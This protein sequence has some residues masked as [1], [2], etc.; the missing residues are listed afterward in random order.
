MVDF[1]NRNIV[2]LLVVV[3]LFIIGFLVNDPFLLF[4][5]SYGRSPLLLKDVAEE[6]VRRIVVI[7]K[8]ERRVFTRTSSGWLLEYGGNNYN[9]DSKKIAENLKKLLDIRRYQKVSSSKDKFQ[10]LE[11]ADDNFHIILEG[12]N[13]KVLARLQLGKAASNYTSTLVRRFGE[14][15]VYSAKGS[16]RSDWNQEVDAYREKTLLLVARPNIKEVVISGKSSFKLAQLGET[17]WQLSYGKKDVP[18]DK[19]RVESFLN[20]LSELKGYRFYKEKSPPLAYKVV[21]Q[22]QGNLTKEL[23]IYGPLKEGEYVA[24]STDN[25]FLLTIS[26]YQVENYLTKPEEFEQKNPGSP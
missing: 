24:S 14:D 4:E 26:K 15:D 16:L 1:R 17:G 2:L 21:L 23:S 11:V 20:Q 3:V 22:L 7:N 18:A 19:N 25:P 5:Q 8:D 12:E 13:S 10:E 9:A 6:D